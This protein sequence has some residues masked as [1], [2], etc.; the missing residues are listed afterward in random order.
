LVEGKFK[1]RY[2]LFSCGFC[3]TAGNSNLLING[4]SF[5]SIA[6]YGASIALNEMSLSILSVTSIRAKIRLTKTTFLLNIIEEIH[7]IS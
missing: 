6:L 2:C 7:P 1:D 3:T 5:K 4:K